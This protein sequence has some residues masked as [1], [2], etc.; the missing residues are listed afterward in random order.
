MRDGRK[1]DDVMVI[2]VVGTAV[3][4]WTHVGSAECE[5]MEYVWCGEVGNVHGRGLEV[6]R[7]DVIVD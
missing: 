3:A 5:G 6:E 2:A 7:V 4:Q 1:V